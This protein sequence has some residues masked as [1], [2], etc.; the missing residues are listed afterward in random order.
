MKIKRI[1]ALLMAIMLLIPSLAMAHEGEKHTSPVQTSAA[2]LR[3]NFGELL[4]TH[5]EYQVLTALK[6]YQGA[7][8][9]D[10]AQEMLEKNANEM[11]AAIKSIYGQKGADQ[12]AEI[13]SSQYEDSASLGMALKNDNAEKEK[14]VKQ[15]LSQDFPKELGAFLE[16]ATGGNLPAETAEKVLMAHE[17]DVIDVVSSYINGDYEKAYNTFDEGYKRMYTIG[18]AL[19]QAIV[20]QMP[21]K[22][23]NTKVVTP[24]SD[25]RV[26]FNQLLGLHFSYQTLT[27]IKQ[28]QGAEDAEVVTEKLEENANEMKAAVKSL[29]GQEGAEQFAKIFS[30]QYENSAGL[31]TA[32]MNDNTEKVEQIKQELLQEFPKELGTF[33]GTATEGNLPAETAEKVLMAHEQDVINVF[34]AYIGEDYEK[35]YQTFD[36]GHKRM[37]MIGTALSGAIAKQMPDKF[38]AEMMPESMPKTGMGGTASNSAWA[39]ISLAV[40]AAGGGALLYRKKSALK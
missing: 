8:D 18:T 26:T 29:Y 24:A 1:F 20:K 13:F 35:A 32:V 5:F 3:A 22:F 40:L 9:A 2:D 38:S 4:A 37:S 14:Q 27:S 15:A 6:Q 34:T 28:F 39:W 10:V 31:G 16:T 23:N 30:S 19:S 17:Q 33:L 36:E 12:F 11:K 21:E 25:L 7:P